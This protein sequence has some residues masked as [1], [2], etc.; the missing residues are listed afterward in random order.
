VEAV[1]NTGLSSSFGNIQDWKE[2]QDKAG[3][4]NRTR[5]YIT[6]FETSQ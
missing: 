2:I 4:G 1:L 6:K 3:E 5:A